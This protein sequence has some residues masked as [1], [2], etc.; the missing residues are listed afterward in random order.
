[1]H[2][3][4][5][6]LLGVVYGLSEVGLALW[7]RAGADTTSKDRHSLLM[8][9]LV[10]GTA[11]GAGIWLSFAWP[12]LSWHAGPATYLAGLTVYLAGLALRWYAIIYLGRFFT[13]NVAIATDHALVQDGPYR[14]VRNPSY[15]GALL[16]FLGLA[17]CLANIASLV[18]IMVPVTAA[19][20]VRIHVEEQ[21]LATAFGERWTAYA[22]RTRRLLPGLY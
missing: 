6:T 3:P 13:V 7:R 12:A 9:W 4:S 5:P 2:L 22:A 1:M 14:R 17:L 19:F 15:T 11:V 10:I 16:A 8:L 21:A 20:L 18:V